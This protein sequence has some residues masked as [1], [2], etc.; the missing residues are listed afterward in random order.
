MPDLSSSMDDQQTCQTSAVLWMVLGPKGPNV[1]KTADLGS[2]IDGFWPRHIFHYNKTAGP[3]Q[4]YGLFWA[5]WQKSQ[6]NCWTP[7]VL[8]MVLGP[9]D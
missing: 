2:S 7:A 6:Q 3:R 9:M 1:I 5:Q 8:W 4:F